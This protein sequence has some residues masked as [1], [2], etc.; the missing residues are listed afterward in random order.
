MGSDL[1]N[2]T[3]CFCE[4]GAL[5]ALFSLKGQPLMKLNGRNGYCFK[6]NFVLS[7]YL[8]PNP[9]TLSKSRRNCCCSIVT[10]ISMLSGDSWTALPGGW[11]AEILALG[12]KFW[13]CRQFFKLGK[14]NFKPTNLC[15]NKVN[16]QFLLWLLPGIACDQVAWLLYS[17]VE[18]S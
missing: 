16:F 3:F 17:P 14:K 5:T 13:A 4:A 2:C 9:L 12:K 1:L 15:V 6:Q 11:G 8:N 18:I 7:V 10:S